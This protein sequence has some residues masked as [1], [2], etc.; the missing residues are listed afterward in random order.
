MPNMLNLINYTV[1]NCSGPLAVLLLAP[2]FA[3]ALAKFRAM[4]EGREGPRFLQPYYDLSKL[5]SKEVILPEASSGIFRIYPY[6]AVILM[7]VLAFAI[8]ILSLKTLYA[9][10]ADA[11]FVFGLFLLVAF[12][13]VLAAMDTGTSF[14]GLG[15]SRE[16]FSMV[17]IEPTI[18]VMLMSLAVE[19]QSTNIFSIVSRNI[20]DR[21]FLLHPNMLFT[22]VAFLVVIIVEC[23][24]F[25]IDNPNTHLELTM[26]HEALVLEYSGKYL[27]L[28]EYASMLKLTL[29]VSLFFSLFYPYGVVDIGSELG[30]EG[31]VFAL[32]I[33][34]AKM[35][36]FAFVFALYEKSTAKLRVFR[37]PELTSFSLALAMIS[38]FAHYFIRI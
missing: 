14:A 37:I 32:A 7:S 24:R 20:N 4:I 8:P 5:M 34:L 21:S 30:V 26:V 29:L 6:L 23:K 12:L 2:L 9:G 36:I 1:L 17:L 28:I 25:P 16:S 33:W 18:L 10:L 3:G 27:A 15:A 35:L 11:I 38:I 22:A 13:A 19:F 31:L